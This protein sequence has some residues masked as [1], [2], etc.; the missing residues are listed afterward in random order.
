MSTL[1]STGRV[2][3]VGGGVATAATAAGLRAGGF[4]GDIVL[5]AEEPHLPYE[6]P[7]L[8]KEFLAGTYVHADF[9]VNP[10]QWYEDN[11]IDLRL[12]TRVASI[13]TAAKTITV[14]DGAAIGYDALVLGTGARPKTLPAASGD[15]VHVLRT[16]ADAERLGARMLPGS[17]IAVLGGGFV[18]CEMAAV[19]AG[20]GA[21]VTLLTQGALPL[22]RTLGSEIGT[23]MLEVHRDAGVDVRCEQTITEV[24]DAGSGL[25]ITTGDGDVLEVDALVVGIGSVPNAALAEDAGLAVD[26]G[27]LTDEFGR[28]SVEDV[29]AIG[30]VASHLHPGYG[31][32]I[33]VEH[34]DTAMRHGQHLARTLLGTPEAFDD[35][36]YFWSDQYEHKLQSLGHFDPDS[37]RIVRGSVEEH[38]FTVFSLVEGRIRAMVALNRPG[39]LLAVRKLLAVSHVVTPEQ[40]ADEQFPLKSLLPQRPRRTPVEVG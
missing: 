32:R 24:I 33:R 4:L 3:L 27:I 9:Q 2:V 31:R 22:G 38:S 37:E 16:I 29:Y 17:R 11:R 28:T 12:S 34:H 14:S 1:P 6:R 13:D 40:L 39:D 36:H 25:R 26:D 30:D 18:G 10:G 8:S 20:R 23:V 21:H 5:V 15:R 7:P 19:A 35:E